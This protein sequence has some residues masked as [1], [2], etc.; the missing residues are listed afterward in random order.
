MRRRVLHGGLRLG[1]EAIGVNRGA[2]GR[3]GVLWIEIF[4]KDA[5]LLRE[6]S[7]GLFLFNFAV[8]SRHFIC[9]SLENCSVKERC[10]RFH[11]IQN[12]KAP[13]Q[14]LTDHTIERVLTDAL[15]HHMEMAL[16]RLTY[17]SDYFGDTTITTLRPLEE[18]RLLPTYTE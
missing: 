5:T 4:D 18:V 11:M 7:L 8:F 12:K 3:A 6:G 13:P 1:T 15:A 17:Y 9:G 10:T 14:P 2:R 16:S